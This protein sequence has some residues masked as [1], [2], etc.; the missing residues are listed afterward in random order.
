MDCSP[1]GSSVHGILPAR[2]L[3]LVAMPPCRGSSK[4]GDR[5]CASLLA[6]VFFTAE[7]PGKPLHTLWEPKGKQT[8]CPEKKSEITVAMRQRKRR[9]KSEDE[10]PPI[11]A[12][13]FTYHKFS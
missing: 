11:I 4:R 3:Q 9:H 1:P 2:I 5:T 8:W 12:K 13:L 10:N 7:P 6:G